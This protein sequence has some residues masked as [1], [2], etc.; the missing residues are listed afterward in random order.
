RPVGGRI[1]SP[2]DPR[3]R[4]ARFPR[5]SFSAIVPRLSLRGNRVEPPFARACRRV[6]G[7]DESTDAVF[8]AG[9]AHKHEVLDHKRSQCEAVALG[10][11]GRSCIPNN[12]SRLAVQ[13]DYMGV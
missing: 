10:V 3:A 4:A 11:F 2:G 5:I 7:F 9:Y 6:V 13:R 12:I 8:A 1:L